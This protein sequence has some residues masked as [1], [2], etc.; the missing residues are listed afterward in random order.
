M[1]VSCGHLYV[2]ECT[3]GRTKIGFTRQAVRQRLRQL[4]RGG[5]NVKAIGIWPAQK[6]D[7]NDAI[8][9][10]AHLRTTGKEWFVDDG[11]I[12]A[13]AK[14]H[15]KRI[16]LGNR[17]KRAHRPSQRRLTMRPTHSDVLLS[18]LAPGTGIASD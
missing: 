11:S 8:E 7:E 9:R 3:D 5:L 16:D 1:S 15:G 6:H 2:V 14:V 10:F 13:W 4:E 12:A 18:H 17:F